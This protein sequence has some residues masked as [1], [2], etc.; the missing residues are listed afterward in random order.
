MLCLPTVSM[1][2]PVMPGW[3]AVQLWVTDEATVAAFRDTFLLIARLSLVT[4]VPVLFVVSPLATALSTAAGVSRQRRADPPS[5]PRCAAVDHRDDG[6][7][8]RARARSYPGRGR[9][10]P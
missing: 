1:G 10:T 2:E 7:G 5:N 8:R 6:S 3:E 9:P 4:I